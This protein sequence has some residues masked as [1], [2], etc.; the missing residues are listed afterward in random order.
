M[1]NRNTCGAGDTC[2]HVCVYVCCAKYK[3]FQVHWSAQPVF[4]PHCQPSCLSQTVLSPWWPSIWRAENSQGKSPGHQILLYLARMEC[5][6]SRWGAGF[7]LVVKMCP[8][9]QMTSGKVPFFCS[10]L[11]N[12]WFG[13]LKGLR[14]FE[15]LGPWA[16]LC[17]LK[18]PTWKWALGPACL[19]KVI[20]MQSHDWCFQTPWYFPQLPIE[21]LPPHHHE[22]ASMREE[23]RSKLSILLPLSWSCWGGE[24]GT[25]IVWKLEWVVA[26]L[27]TYLSQ[28][29]DLWTS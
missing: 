13:K 3:G 15:I 27:K 23:D 29:V 17:I 7:I 11:G 14:V 9:G 16:L 24:K 28:D 8:Q 10:W 1:Y 4:I 20:P 12:T 5:E 2:L 21:L 6:G 22:V 19:P 26:P 18:C 25:F